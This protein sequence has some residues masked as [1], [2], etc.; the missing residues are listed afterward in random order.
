MSEGIRHVDLNVHKKIWFFGE[1]DPK[2]SQDA[3]MKN[4]QNIFDIYNR[5]YDAPEDEVVTLLNDDAATKRYARL[6]EKLAE[7]RNGAELQQM[8]LSS[9]SVEQV[10]KLS[11][12]LA[13]RDRT[14]PIAGAE[15][16]SS[17]FNQ[18]LKQIYFP[19]QTLKANFPFVTLA[20]QIA[21]LDNSE[22]K[23]AM[24]LE[25]FGQYNRNRQRWM[26]GK[27]NEL[28]QI[29]NL[30]N[31]LIPHLS[32]EDFQTIQNQIPTLGLSPTSANDLNEKMDAAIAS[33]N[34]TLLAE[35]AAHAEVATPNPA[36]V[37]ILLE[38][39][40]AW[41]AMHEEVKNAEEN[42][43]PEV[44]PAEEYTFAEGTVEEEA[45]NSL[46]ENVAEEENP[47]ENNDDSDEEEDEEERL[48]RNLTTNLAPSL[49]RPPID[50]D[51]ENTDE[52]IEGEDIQY[53]TSP[54]NSFN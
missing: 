5:N 54:T 3:E 32:A 8:M 51:G 52:D 34:N 33:K 15:T 45:K 25:L 18:A 2:I 27:N 53:T 38:E 1:R 46:D 17:R 40:A 49:N 9:L 50:D 16:R 14:S 47:D 4:W 12:E 20:D 29:E 6:F 26:G 21:V 41:D 23:K 36:P 7:E 28:T 22:Q 43:D 19:T 39:N 10:G 31:K 30:L 37:P 42:N 11:K 24:I 35:A 48:N 13:N 44:N